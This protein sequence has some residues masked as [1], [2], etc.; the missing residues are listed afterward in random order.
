LFVGVGEGSANGRRGFFLPCERGGERG[1]ER[2][3]DS[4]GRVKLRTARV[5]T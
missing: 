3:N 1:G 2:S 5:M 4:K